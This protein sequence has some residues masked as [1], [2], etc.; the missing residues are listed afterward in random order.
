VV[1]PP[2][3][4]APPVR[5]LPESGGDAARGHAIEVPAEACVSAAEAARRAW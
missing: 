4:P 1:P 2:L 3:R 5:P